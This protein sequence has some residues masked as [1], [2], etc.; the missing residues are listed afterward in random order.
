MP[1]L[2]LTRIDFSKLAQGKSRLSC[3]CQPKLIIGELNQKK[4]VSKKSQQLILPLDEL[5]IVTRGGEKR[6]FDFQGV[7]SFF[8]DGDLRVY[9]F[10]NCDVVS[11]AF[12][13]F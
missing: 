8:F 2:T 12:Q 10:G 9:L 4:T 6:S 5:W 3:F 13:Q 7:S 11:N 1:S